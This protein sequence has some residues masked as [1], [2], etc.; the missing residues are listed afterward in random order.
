MYWAADSPPR[1]KQGRRPHSKGSMHK[2]ELGEDGWMGKVNGWMLVGG[3]LDGWVCE[4][5]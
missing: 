3:W 1:N 4:V 2:V 5:R